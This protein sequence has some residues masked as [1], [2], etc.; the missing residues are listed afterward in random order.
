MRWRVLAL[1]SLGVNLALAAVWFFVLRQPATGPSTAG[2]SAGAVT[3]RN[4]PV[5]V[6]RRQFFSWQE[7]ESDDY[8]TY[9]TNLRDIGCPEQTIRDI[10]IADVNALYAKRRALEVVTPMQQWWRSEPDTNV[11]LAAAQKAR[12]LDNERRALLTGLLGAGWEG[13]DLVSLPRPSRQPVAL[14]GP[15]LGSLATDVKQALQEISARSADR[16]QAYL[17][18]QQAQGKPADA[19][20]LARLRQQTRDELARVLAPPQLEEFLLRYSQEANDLRAEFGQLKYFSPTP[21]EFRSVFRATDA[22]DQQI[23]ALAD[24]TD[25]TSGR[26]RQ[27]LE[28]QRENA[29]KNALGPRRYEEYRNLQDPLYRDA[30]ATAQQ[31]G[32]P[33]A[34]RSIYQVSLA[35]AAEQNSILADTNLTADQRNIALKSLEL[36]QLKANAIVSGQDLPPEPPPPPAPTPRRT[37]TIRPGDSAAVVG[38]IYGVPESAIRAANPGVNFN[39]LKPGDSIVIPRNAL[40]PIPG[41]R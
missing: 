21:D 7:V 19:V 8:P 31:S 30:V 34:A 1:V 29:I 32:N 20:D 3:N 2:L 16:M 27:A 10:I 40:S 35:A 15:L 41:P 36:D 5:L 6:V 33:D 26:A 4:R 13:G 17:E 23:A 22:L 39:R 14:D 37:Y 28:V 38:L 18:A 12:A 11:L 25:M 24:A 9:I